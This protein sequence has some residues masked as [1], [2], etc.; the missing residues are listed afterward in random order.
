MFHITFHPNRSITYYMTRGAHKS[1]NKQLIQ[2]NLLN[3]RRHL[4]DTDCNP[5]SEDENNT[6][7]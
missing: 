4:I 3:C 7:K 5:I 6:F 2:S 1:Q